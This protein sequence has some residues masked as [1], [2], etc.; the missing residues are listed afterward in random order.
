MNIYKDGK[1]S[2]KDIILPSFSYLVNYPKGRR[3]QTY[4]EKV[5]LFNNA[6][7]SGFDISTKDKIRL[8]QLEEEYKVKMKDEDH[9]M[10][11]DNCREKVCECDWDSV[12]KCKQCPRQMFSTEKIDKQWLKWKQRRD[13][14]ARAAEKKDN[15]VIETVTNIETEEEE[16]EIVAAMSNME[17][18]T[19]ISDAIFKSP[20][21]KVTTRSS[22]SASVDSGRGG[23]TP[24]DSLT[25]IPLR[26]GPRT[27]NPQIMRAI[28]HCQSTYKISDNDIE[29]I[30]VDIANMV[31]GQNWRKSGSV[32]LGDEEESDDENVDDGE[33]E[34]PQ[35][36]RRNI[37]NYTF[38]SRQ[39]RRKWLRHGAILNLKYVS[40][41]IL[42][43]TEEEVVTWG[44]DDTTKA[45]G[46]RLLDV[47]SSNIT[48]G[49]DDMERETLTTGFTPNLSHSGRDQ[50]I[51]LRHSLEVLSVL[52]GEEAGEKFSVDDVIS[53]IDFWMSD[54]SADGDVLLNDLGVEDNKRLKCNAHVILT[55]DDA[56][57]YV[58]QSAEAAIGQDKLI[59][60][61]A[62]NK[63]F[64][65]KSSIPTLGLI[66]LAK[67]S[68]KE[69][70]KK[71]FK[72][73][74]FYL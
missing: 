45:A 5:K 39:A 16:P 55:I 25:R 70:F 20:A 14:E 61:K 26:F 27:L 10:L 66:A 36:K 17:D 1:K 51:T 22:S 59:G 42:H 74:D 43:K 47:K 3:N 58:M 68:R 37:D 24:V 69:F 11:E 13:R 73:K 41:R 46:H 6:M 63:A 71:G 49:G 56:I 8:K 28:I 64:Q 53:Q 7:R 34:P 52:A 40:D 48:I 72:L 2:G 19:F 44:F 4:E 38:P 57:D 15:A 30:F 21:A 60:S 32:S 12:I 9:Q 33:D 23:D 31:F 35:K 67:V 65:S 50:A 18:E 54:R 29:G 62:G